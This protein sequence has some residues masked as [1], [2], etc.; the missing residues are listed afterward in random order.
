MVVRRAKTK[1]PFFKPYKFRGMGIAVQTLQT[2]GGSAAGEEISPSDGTAVEAVLVSHLE[3][4]RVIQVVRVGLNG[5]LVSDGLEDPNAEPWFLLQGR[6]HGI[7]RYF[8]AN[9]QD[10]YYPVHTHLESPGYYIL[11]KQHHLNCGSIV[12]TRH[13]TKH[14]P[15]D[16]STFSELDRDLVHEAIQAFLRTRFNQ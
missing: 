6:H 16:W 14:T 10:E 8:I 12:S 13:N 4:C 7:D 11:P 1:Q 15:Y 9:D 2:L 5:R 3:A